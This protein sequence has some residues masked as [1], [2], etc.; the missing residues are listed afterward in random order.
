MGVN[1]AKPVTGI[2]VSAFK[3]TIV[4]FC[5]FFCG[6]LFFDG[7]ECFLCFFK[8]ECFFFLYNVYIQIQSKVLN[9]KVELPSYS[10]LCHV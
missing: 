3:S 6:L 8:G 4:L 7:L 10:T 1:H 5:A 2:V 9:S